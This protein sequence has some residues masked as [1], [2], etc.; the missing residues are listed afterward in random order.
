MRAC[1]LPASSFAAP[2]QPPA[3]SAPTKVA[4]SAIAPAQAPAKTIPTQPQATAEPTSAIS[5]ASSSSITSTKDI[6][7]TAKVCAATRHSV[8]EPEG[9]PPIYPPAAPPERIQA[10]ARQSD[11][12]HVTH[13]LLHHTAKHVGLS[14]S[15][16]VDSLTKDGREHSVLPIVVCA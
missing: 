11:I 4:P 1:T 7:T 13:D 15:R 3:V 16:L 6:T 9:A 14:G 5:S 12:R 2:T 10:P 8:S